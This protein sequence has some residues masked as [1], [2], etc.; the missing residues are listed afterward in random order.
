MGWCMG[1]RDLLRVGSC[2]ICTYLF[3]LMRITCE[4]AVPCRPMLIAEIGAQARRGGARSSSGHLLQ[5]V[6][7]PA[8]A[9]LA[10]AAAGAPGP[11]PGH[12]LRWH[13]A[14]A[15]FLQCVREGLI[16]LYTQFQSAS[17]EQKPFTVVLSNCGA[18]KMH[19]TLQVLTPGLNAPSHEDAGFQAPQCMYNSLEQPKRTHVT[20]RPRGPCMRWRPTRPH[21]PGA[22]DIYFFLKHPGPDADALCRQAPRPLHEMASDDAARAGREAAAA[23]A[24][25][26]LAAECTFRPRLWAAPSGARLGVGGGTS[27]RENKAPRLADQVRW[28]RRMAGLMYV[29]CCI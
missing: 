24:E 22:H 8:A 20:G 19:H 18:L 13:Q 3:V 14:A 28:G 25:A 9:V 23:E 7:L 27:G 12:A 10:L 4:H 5:P 17:R 16:F 29:L 26:R 2:V 1:W 15:G 11:R 6:Q 21:A